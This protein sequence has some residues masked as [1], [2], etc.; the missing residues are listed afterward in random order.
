MLL[1]H[2]QE[3][4]TTGK[5]ACLFCVIMLFLSTPCLFLEECKLQTEHTY[6]LAS[7]QGHSQIYLAAME[8]NLGEGLGSK[9]HKTTLWTGNGG[10]GLY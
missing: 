5:E 2:F 1:L 9:L 7:S 6:T 8:K 4:Q 10:L 3:W